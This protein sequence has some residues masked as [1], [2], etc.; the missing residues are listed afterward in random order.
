[1]PN[2]VS[3]SMVISGETAEVQAFI[4]KARGADSLVRNDDQRDLHFGAFIHPTDEDLPYYRGDLKEEKPENWEEL[5]P[6][7]QMAHSLKFSG[8]D[9]YDWNIREW[10]TK[11]DACDVSFEDLDPITYNFS[12]AWSIP[13]PVFRA[14]VAEFPTLEFDFHCEEEQGWGATFAGKDGE[15]SLVEEWDI[16]NSHADYVDRDNPDGC[17]CAWNDDKDDW[18][19]DCPN[20][21]P[22]YVRVTKTYKLDGTND[23]TE[24]R[25]AYF[26]IENGTASLPEEE[27]GL[28][29]F[30]FVDEDGEEIEDE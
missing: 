8:R 5:S 25:T 28:S 9:W 1:M 11:W 23:L 12:T 14:M 24:A 3:N 6:A 2:W 16:P 26:E 21:R 20:K 13:E 15:L 10:G 4:E 19:D 22:I 30:V 17:N 7:E 29:S 18:Y 27:D